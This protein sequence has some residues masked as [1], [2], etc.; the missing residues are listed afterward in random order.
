MGF[1]EKNLQ[2]AHIFIF[3]S[4]LILS[5][6]AWKIHSFHT[7][8][9]YWIYLV[10]FIFGFVLIGVVV[11]LILQVDTKLGHFLCL[12]DYPKYHIY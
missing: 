10:V 9:P 12:N 3:L 2:I 5:Y 4:V 6:S 1:L 8:R 11:H 7:N